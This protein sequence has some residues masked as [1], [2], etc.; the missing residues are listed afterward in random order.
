MMGRAGRPQYDT[1]GVAAIIT[2]D[3]RHSFYEKLCQANGAIESSLKNSFVEHLNSEI[4]LGNVRNLEEGLLWLKSTYYYVRAI[5]NPEHYLGPSID[6]AERYLLNH[7]SDAVRVLESN[8]LLRF[9]EHNMFRS[10]QFGSA[11]SRFCLDL[12]STSRY[13]STPKAASASKILQ[14]LSKSHE[15][16][17]IKFA[18]GDKGI[19][20]QILKENKV[21][22][23]ETSGKIKEIWE[24]IFYSIQVIFIQSK[25]TN[26]G[27]LSSGTLILAGPTPRPLIKTHPTTAHRLS[28]SAKVI[29]Q[30]FKEN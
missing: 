6:N 27:R 14:I 23:K 17:D 3:S 8:D 24:K 16:I 11:M 26:T 5:K 28:S 29:I 30:S 12:E 1:F 2:D 25:F 9:T 10:T 21:R 22:F 4:V 13:I 15:F 20:N 7:V 19:I 18:S